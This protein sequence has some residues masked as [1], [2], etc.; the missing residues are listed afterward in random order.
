MEH[1]YRYSCCEQAGEPIR[2]YVGHGKRIDVGLRRQLASGS[3]AIP[4]ERTYRTA[5]AGSTDNGGEGAQLPQRHPF[6]FSS[7]VFSHAVDSE[8]PQRHVIPKDLQVATFELGVTPSDCV[9]Q[10]LRKR[11]IR[12]GGKILAHDSR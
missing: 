11:R 6:G 5:C 9:R 12:R 2:L 4:D 7:N 1:D 10:T 8:R 3:R